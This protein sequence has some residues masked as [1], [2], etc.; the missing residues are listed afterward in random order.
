MKV[1]VTWGDPSF[2]GPAPMCDYVDK[3]I[4]TGSVACNYQ[5]NP[6]PHYSEAVFVLLKNQIL[7]T[8]QICEVQ[9]TYEDIYMQ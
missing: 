6:A 3:T 8:A 1:G 4:G 5:C 2:D 9:Y 7:T